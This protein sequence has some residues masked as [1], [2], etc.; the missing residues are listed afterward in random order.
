[1]IKSKSVLI[2]EDEFLIADFL[3]E[4]VS[5]LGM[6]LMGIASTADTAVALAVQHRPDVVLMD[7]RLK[8]QRDGVDAAIDIHQAVK[9]A[10]VYITG[11]NEPAN[12]ARIHSDH[13]AAVLFK[14]T[15]FEELA[16]TLN[17]VCSNSDPCGY[18]AE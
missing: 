10:I 12:V 16:E 13:P 11:S 3:S 5:D 14:P 8:G 17:K 18:S 15:S 9:S 7:V 2:V 6:Q 1:M 4:V